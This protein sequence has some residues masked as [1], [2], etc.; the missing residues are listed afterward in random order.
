MEKI[1]VIGSHPD[2]ETLGAGGA[3]ARHRFAGDEVSV[4]VLTEGVTARH[5]EV[6]KQQQAALAAC[7]A[8]G[9]TD[10]HFSGLPDQRL[11]AMPLLEVIQP[12]SKLISTLMPDVIYTHH[13]GDLNQDHRIVF[14]ATMIAVRPLGERRIKRVLCYEVPSSTEWAPPYSDRAF[15]PNVFINIEKQLEKKLEALQAYSSTHISEVPSYPHPRSIEAVKNLAR[16]R[17]IQSGMSAAEAFCLARE[18]VR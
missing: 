6:E 3:I 2:D 17:G 15:M 9:V 7:S 14:N 13:G 12:I 18:I 8:L 1:L 4:L 16:Q 10:V 11:D 5:R